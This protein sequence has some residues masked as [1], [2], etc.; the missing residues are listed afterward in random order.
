MLSD[1][2]DVVSRSRSQIFRTPIVSAEYKIAESPDK[3]SPSR[4]ST[5]RL[6]AE[7]LPTETNGSAPDMVE[8]SLD[9]GEIGGCLD[10]A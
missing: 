3:A 9:D 8:R 10:A 1:D 5:G 7:M 4:A 6:C 2:W